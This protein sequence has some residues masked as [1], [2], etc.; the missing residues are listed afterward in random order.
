MIKCLTCQAT[1]E[2]CETIVTLDCQHDICYYCLP[3]DQRC[4]ICQSEILEAD[5]VYWKFCFAVVNYNLHGLTDLTGPV[6]KLYELAKG[7]L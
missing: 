2:D 5:L 6:T 4:P 1:E 7:K 3:T